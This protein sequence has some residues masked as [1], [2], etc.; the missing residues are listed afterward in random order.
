MITIGSA[1]S[2]EDRGVRAVWV[3]HGPQRPWRRQV[4]RPE[5]KTILQVRS[6]QEGSFRIQGRQNI[7]NNTF[8]NNLFNICMIY[9]YI[10][11]KSPYPVL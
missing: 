10:R 5:I 7:F 1:D 3:D 11:D 6:S 2:G 9:T 8:L 4:R